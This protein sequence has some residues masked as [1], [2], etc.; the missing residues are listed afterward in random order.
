MLPGKD[1]E[2]N[3]LLIDKDF[4]IGKIIN[5]RII[6]IPEGMVYVDGGKI[7]RAVV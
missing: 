1:N 3:W 5:F 4:I 7:T 6:T 2:D